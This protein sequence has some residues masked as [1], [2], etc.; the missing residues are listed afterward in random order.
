MKTSQAGLAIT[1]TEW[2]ISL[3][4]ARRALR[5]LGVG[6]QE[7]NDVIALLEQYKAEIVE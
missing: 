6:G 5:E 4:C 7:T 2:E 1:E 3:D